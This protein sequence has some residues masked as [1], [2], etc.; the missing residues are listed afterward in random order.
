MILLIALAITFFL[1]GGAF[2][3]WLLIWLERALPP[4]KEKYV[5]MPHTA[6]SEW[7]DVTDPLKRGKVPPQFDDAEQHWTG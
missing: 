1:L 3:T 7:H 4:H 5:G 6:F 2:A